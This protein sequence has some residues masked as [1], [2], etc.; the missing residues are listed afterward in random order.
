MLGF[1]GKGTV[2][3]KCDWTKGLWPNH[4]TVW[5]HGL[6]MSTEL[7][8]TLT[9]SSLHQL[10]VHF[11]LMVNNSP[12]QPWSHFRG[13][14]TE[15][16]DI[17]MT[18]TVLP[19]RWAMNWGLNPKG[20]APVRKSHTAMM[21]DVTFIRPSSLPAPSLHPMEVQRSLGRETRRHTQRVTSQ[22]SDLCCA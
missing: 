18:C 17:L 11:T 14:E 8:Q 1:G 16:Q 6:W 5:A 4:G 22:P 7:K 10:P 13:K 15:I 12:G 21:C 9:E 3:H 2:M 19:P 20:V